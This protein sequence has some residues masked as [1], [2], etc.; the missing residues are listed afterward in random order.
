MSKYPRNLNVP[1]ST[2]WAR[3]KAQAK[4]R[5]E[6]YELTLE[7]YSMLWATQGISLRTDHTGRRSNSVAM[8]RINALKPWRVDNVKF[9]T[10]LEYIQ[11]HHQRHTHSS[12]MEQ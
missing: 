8:C 4:Y 9:M 11:H 7:Q 3:H 1:M 10:R 6:P 5:S 2:R 12:Y